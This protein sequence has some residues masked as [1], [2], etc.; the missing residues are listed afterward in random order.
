[1]FILPSL[2]LWVKGI[3]GAHPFPQLI[4]YKKNSNVYLESKEMQLKHLAFQ[5]VGPLINFQIFI[6]KIDFFVNQIKFLRKKKKI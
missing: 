3:E 4:L 2:R 6:N 5:G 1:M